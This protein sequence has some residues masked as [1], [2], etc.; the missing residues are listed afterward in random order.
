[1][2]AGLDLAVARG[3][4]TEERAGSIRAE[5]G[6]IRARL[7]E[8]GVALGAEVSPRVLQAAQSYR[9]KAAAA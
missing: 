6:S 9:A 8:G 4:L 3:A 5:F 1:M 2:A 7:A